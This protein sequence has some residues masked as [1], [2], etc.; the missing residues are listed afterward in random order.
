MSYVYL[1]SFTPNNGGTARLY[2]W[3]SVRFGVASCERP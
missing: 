1:F 3:Y 2:L